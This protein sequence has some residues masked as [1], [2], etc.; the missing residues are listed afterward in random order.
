MGTLGTARSVVGWAAWDL[1]DVA[2]ARRRRPSLDLTA[3]AAARGF[4]SHGSANAGGWSGVLPGE[5]ELQANVVRGTTPGGWDCCLWH[6]RQPVPVVDA[7]RGPTLIGGPQ[8]DLTLRSPLDGLPRTGGRRYVGVPVTA[9]AVAVPEA[10]LLAPFTLG[11]PDP[12]AGGD[13]PVPRLRARLEAGPLG[14]VLRAG[15]RFALLEL[16]WGGGVLIVRRNGYADEAGMDELLPVLDD[17]ARA[18]AAV[19]AP[20]HSPA[21]FGAP[22]PAATR[23]EPASPLL[24]EVH[25]LGRRLGMV[26][27]DPRAYHRAFPTG[28]VPGTALAVL[29]GALPGRAATA[30]IAVHA[31][32]AGPG[33][34]GRTALLLAAGAA[35]ATEPGGV[36]VAGSPVP[37]RYAVRG[38]VLGVWVLRRPPPDLGPVDELL[39][40]S[41]ALERRLG[42]GGGP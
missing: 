16:S 19:C 22:L 3:W 11:A 8:H 24:A 10:A 14:A 18:L 28:P 6:W 7:P 12:G 30:R 13:Q 31:D 9:A 36:R 4:D 17:C 33:A 15:S 5:P 2:D 20:L 39:A 25:R 35:A 27:E 29:R 26:T 1:R 23:P 41:V 42:L 34:G 40:A 32:P 37:M 21:P 38:G